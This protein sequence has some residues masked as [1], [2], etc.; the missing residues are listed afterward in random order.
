MIGRGLMALLG[1]AVGGCVLILLLSWLLEWAIFKRVCDR[2]ETGIG[3]SVGLAVAFA[4]V[5]YGFGHGEGG[6][7]SPMPGGL[8]YVVAGAIVLPW[9][10]ISYRRRRES[11][12]D[13]EN[14]ATSFE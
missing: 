5:L 10:L 8:A 3:L 4:I 9:R 6:A 14:V 11:R 1:M 12:A 2:A 13:A 7:W